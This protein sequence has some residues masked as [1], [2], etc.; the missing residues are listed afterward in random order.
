M[1]LPAGP[2]TAERQQAIKV[3]SRLLRALIG[4][5]VAGLQTVSNGQQIHTKLLWK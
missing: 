1:N 3:I 4:P 2:L 5:D